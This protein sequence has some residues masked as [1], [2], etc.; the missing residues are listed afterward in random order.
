MSGVATTRIVAF[1][2]EYPPGSP[3]EHVLNNHKGIDL[4]GQCC[5]SRLPLARDLKHGAVMPGLV[6]WFVTIA[7]ILFALLFLSTAHPAKETDLCS[8]GLHLPLDDNRKREGKRGALAGLRLDPDF[9]AVHFDDALRYGEPQAGAALLA[10][11][12]I[13]GLLKLLK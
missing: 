4:P 1:C 9:A 10:R 13:V 5:R 2:P 11:D 7:D 12:R 3:W 8:C 6:G